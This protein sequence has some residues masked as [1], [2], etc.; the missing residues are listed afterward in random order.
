MNEARKGAA[1]VGE[2]K[3]TGR[4][5]TPRPLGRVNSESVESV[6]AYGRRVVFYAGEVD[7]DLLPGGRRACRWTLRDT[8]ATERKTANRA[9]LNTFTAEEEAPMRRRHR[10]IQYWCAEYLEFVQRVEQSTSHPVKDELNVTEADARAVLHTDPM[11][12]WS[13]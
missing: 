9:D 10:Q 3:A 13:W 5:R 6:L 4:R 11:R 8:G 7:D 12:H 2:P 1:G